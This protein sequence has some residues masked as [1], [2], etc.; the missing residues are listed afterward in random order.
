M[1]I[2]EGAHLGRD[3]ARAAGPLLDIGS[4]DPAFVTPVHVCEAAKAAIDAGRTHCERNPDQGEAIAMTL[5]RDHGIRV[6]PFGG[7]VVTP[8]ARLAI[9][10][11]S[12]S[13]PR[14][15]P[16]PTLWETEVF[17]ERAMVRLCTREFAERGS[18]AGRERYE[19]ASDP[20]TADPHDSFARRAADLVGAIDERC[21]PAV[22]GVAGIRALEVR[23][24][25]YRSAA[26]WRSV[27]IAEIAADRG[28]GGVTR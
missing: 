12:T 18:D 19:T 23:L 10:T 6:D 7:R 11:L 1:E 15:R 3:A 28:E 4:G 22:D 13:A 27:T 2:Y 26:E 14:Y 17:T 20:A 5:G 25:I 9:A 8:G 21:A 24:A 16:E